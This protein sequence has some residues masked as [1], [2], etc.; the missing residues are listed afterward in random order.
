MEK[1]ERRGGVERERGHDGKGEEVVASLE[2][3]GKR[4]RKE[5]RQKC[6]QEDLTPN[7][8]KSP[9]LNAPT[10]TPKSSE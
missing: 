3:C 4:K 9:H 2:Q 7:G 8:R 5:G 10:L 6:S 1:T